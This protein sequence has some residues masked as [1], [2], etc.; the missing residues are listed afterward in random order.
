MIALQYKML[1]AGEEEFRAIFAYECN[2]GRC[3]GDLM[4]YV[5]KLLHCRL[6]E[7]P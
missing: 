1:P 3:G 7:S 4:E 6:E 2:I 5:E